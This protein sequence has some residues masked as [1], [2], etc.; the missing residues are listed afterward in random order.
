MEM[1]GNETL[2][3]YQV[4][5]IYKHSLAWTVISDRVLFAVNQCS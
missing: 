1:I 3:V 2:V 5:N 4:T